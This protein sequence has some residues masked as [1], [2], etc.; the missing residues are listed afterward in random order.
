LPH[1]S[2]AI[3]G[4]ALR[5]KLRDWAGYFSPGRLYSVSEALSPNV[6]VIGRAILATIAGLEKDIHPLLEEHGISE[7]HPDEWYPQ[8]LW[9]DVLEAISEGWGS[10]GAIMDLVSVGMRIP[11]NALWPPEVDN[12]EAALFSIDV[13]YKMNHRGGEI[14]SYTAQKLRDAIFAS[15]AITPIPTIWITASSIA[16]RRSFSP[17]GITRAC[18]QSG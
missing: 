1:A 5:K 16:P 8:Q 14:G 6:E 15:S 17:G 7:I 13:A 10:R 3:G 18:L 4:F 12:V 2:R 9:L 11:E